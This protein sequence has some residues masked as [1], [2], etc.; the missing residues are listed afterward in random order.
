MIHEHTKFLFY[1]M[2]EILFNRLCKPWYHSEFVFR[3][4]PLN[5][6]QQKNL[7]VLHG[8]TRSVIRTRKGELLVRSKNQIR[9]E[10]HEVLGEE[11]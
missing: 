8:L 2:G 9:E 5:R 4:S 11:C 6:Q 7:A 1:S 3:L 10:D